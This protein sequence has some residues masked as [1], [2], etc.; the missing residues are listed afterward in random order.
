MIVVRWAVGDA[1]WGGFGGRR[2]GKLFG[3]EKAR[4]VLGLRLFLE[5]P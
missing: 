1:E 2:R 5:G 3:G 4:S